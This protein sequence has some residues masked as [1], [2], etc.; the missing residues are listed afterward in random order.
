VSKGA[1]DFILRLLQVRAGDRLTAE[2]SVSHPWLRVANAG[3]PMQSFLADGRNGPLNHSQ[4]PHPLEHARKV[5]GRGAP[6][7]GA[8]RGRGAN[9]PPVVTGTVPP[10][11]APHGVGYV[12]CPISVPRGQYA[13]PSY[14]PV[15]R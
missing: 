3:S 6:G 9:S 14:M 5:N 12:H 4:P 15:R 13:Q 1:Q 7:Q 11:G 10:P 2:Q 8:G